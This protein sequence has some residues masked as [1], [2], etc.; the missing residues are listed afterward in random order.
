MQSKKPDIPLRFL[1]LASYLAAALVFV[2]IVAPIAQKV[3]SV[4]AALS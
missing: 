3:A 2:M 4:L 1:I